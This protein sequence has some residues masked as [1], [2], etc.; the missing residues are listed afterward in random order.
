MNI[1]PT[2]FSVVIGGG[3]LAILAQTAIAQQWVAT[4][5]PSALQTSVGAETHLA[6]TSYQRQTNTVTLRRD[7]LDEP[8]YLTLRSEGASRLNGQILINDR[9][10]RN[11]DAG[12]LTVD[13]APYLTTGTTTVTLTAD[14]A[15][16]NASV[17]LRFEGP[18]TT[19]S[20]QLSGTGQL[21]Y[22]LVLDV[23]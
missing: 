10:V 5:L 19:V 1:L 16:T 17:V 7:L 20:Q 3:C 21:N 11:L 6:M 22:Q 9:I 14:Y 2:L 8:H 4:S 23:R 15:P 18:E 13:L 12:S